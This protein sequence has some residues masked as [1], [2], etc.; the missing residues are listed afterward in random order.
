M[1]KQ[2]IGEHRFLSNFYPVTIIFRGQKYPSV[3]HAYMSAKCDDPKWKMTC[4]S[5]DMSAGEIK[6]LG[7]NVDLVSD[8]EEIK[9]NVMRVCLFHKFSQ[10]KFKD[11]LLATG[12]QLLFE[13]NDWGDKYWGIDNKTGEGLNKLGKL[14][15]DIRADLKEVYR[16][17]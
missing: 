13:G 14:L 16:G 2:F 15:M 8:W 11:L 17:N 7:R 4:Q 9:D 1:I 6:R 5:T 12:D 10:T 3:E